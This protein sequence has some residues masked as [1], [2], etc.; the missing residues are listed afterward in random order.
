IGGKAIRGASGDQIDDERGGRTGEQRIAQRRGVEINETALNA[1]GA[2]DE[3]AGNGAG[4]ASGSDRLDRGS[5]EAL[6]K[7]R[8]PVDVK[9]AIGGLERG[10]R[11]TGVGKNRRPGTIRSEPRPGG[12]AQGDN[13]GVEFFREPALGRF[14]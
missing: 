6:D 13:G 4:S 9:T 10:K 11:N 1:G 2:D 7:D 5:S 14:E 8:A 12:T 3:L